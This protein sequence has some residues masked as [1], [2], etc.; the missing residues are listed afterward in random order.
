MRLFLHAWKVV[1]FILKLPRV[2][3]LTH[4]SL[5]SGISLL[6]MVT[7]DQFDVITEGILL[8]QKRSWKMHE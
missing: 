4:S 8:G 5:Y 2:S 6:D 7:L 3:I 1:L